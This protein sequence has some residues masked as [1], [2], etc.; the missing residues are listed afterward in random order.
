MHWTASMHLSDPV[1]PLYAFFAGGVLGRM[2]LE[3]ALQ[4]TRRVR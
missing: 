4:L 2:T 1:A 3:L